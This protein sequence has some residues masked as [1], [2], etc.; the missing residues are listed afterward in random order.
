MFA[1]IHPFFLALYPVLFLY[2]HNINQVFFREILL[3]TGIVLVSTL[4]LVLLLI[5]TLRNHRKAGIIASALLVPFFAY[6][7]FI[8]YDPGHAFKTTVAPICML[9]IFL[10][11]IAYAVVR[12]KSD[13]RNTT[14]IINIV[15]L[16]LVS[17]PTANILYYQL[18]TTKYLIVNESSE[19]LASDNMNSYKPEKL[20]DIYYIIFDR[21]ASPNTLK[22][23]YGFD[24]SEFL[25]FL[26]KKGFYVAH[27]SRANYVKTAHSLASSLNMKYVNYLNKEYGGKSE[28]WKPLYLMLTDYFVWRF[29]KERGYKYI[30]FG[31]WWTPTHKNQNADLNFNF[32][33]WWNHGD[34]KK[35]ADLNTSVDSIFKLDQLFIE[36]PI[37]FYRHTL[38]YQLSMIFTDY[39]NIEATDEQSDIKKVLGDR[40]LAAR[41]RILYKFDR[42]VE[43]PKL[44]S[45]TFVFAH[46]LIPHEPY[47]FDKDGSFPSKQE[48]KSRGR[49]ENYINQLIYT[50]TK[51]EELVNKLL[52]KSK[53]KPIIIIQSDEGPFPERYH[54]NAKHFK[55]EKATKKEL[56]QKMGILNAYYLPNVEKSLLYPS[57]T[58]VN[59]FRLIFNL[60]FNTDFELLPDKSFVFEDEQHIYNM[61]DVTE[62]L[63]YD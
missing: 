28:D 40:R 41:A 3:S 43:I 22:D 29:L 21:Y 39:E 20:P 23:H 55:W 2:A 11:G 26:E 49:D 63:D 53:E 14:F 44:K 32:G 27:K 35:Y 25:S 10:I 36:F 45:P 51:I 62:T 16:V 9:G 8:T 61:I 15:S 6:G 31:S 48:L 7:H 33:S 46:M 56:R 19:S 18:S 13:L 5:I 12:T 4:V 57:I 37:E 47:A 54:N 38:I 60:Y 24:N 34:K 42:L 1:T 50:N 59:T 17:M 52:S 30:H 58:P